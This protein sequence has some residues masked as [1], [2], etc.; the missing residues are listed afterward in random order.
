MKNIDA[1]LIFV[2]LFLIAAC[3]SEAENGPGSA[4]AAGAGASS[5]PPEVG[6][7]RDSSLAGEW[8]IDDKALYATKVTETK[9]DLAAEQKSTTLNE[10]QLAAI[11]KVVAAST[12]S[13]QLNANGTFQAQMTISEPG[14][15]LSEKSSGTWTS[16]G[17]RLELSKTHIDGEAQEPPESE[18]LQIKDGALQTEFLGHTL[19]MKRK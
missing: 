1:L 3:G 15:E 2:V 17:A 13:I 8:V 5:R 12:R 18:T 6:G 7:K 11:R 10:K 16:S 4:P 14:L 9:A 19:P